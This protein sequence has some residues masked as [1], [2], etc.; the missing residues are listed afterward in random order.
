MS[1]AGLPPHELRELGGDGARLGAPARRAGGGFDAGAHLA[2]H[3]ACATTGR[4]CARAG[5][6][7]RRHGL[8]SGRARGRG[9]AP[10]LERL[11]AGD[12]GSGSS[13][14]RRTGA[15]ERRPPRDRWRAYRPRCRLGRWSALPERLHADGRS[16]GSSLRD[17]PRAATR[18]PLG[19]V[20]LGRPGAQSVGVRSAG[21]SSS[22]EAFSRRRS[23]ARPEPFN[24]ASE[25]RTRA[26][27][28]DAGFT[29]VRT[30]EVPVRFA[31]SDV[32]DYETLGDG[33]QRLVRDGSPRLAR[34]RARGTQ[35]RAPRRVRALCR[36][37]K[38]TSSAASP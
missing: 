8:R 30:D 27:L 4:H 25:E 32:D 23:P 6:R 21:G 22:S 28:G 13:S 24:M 19:D 10:H 31:F 38:A 16:C 5:G 1:H 26:L 33:P 36:R 37:S 9:R 11:L 2:D 14:G 7:A 15:R 18:R 20:G 17:A 35:G 34:G 3:P 12:G 29:D